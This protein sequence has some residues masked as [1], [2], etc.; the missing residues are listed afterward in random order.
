MVE[1]FKTNVTS[2]HQARV[3]VSLIQYH[4]EGF[5]ANFDLQDCDHILR[6]EVASHRKIEVDPVVNL[7]RD[8]GVRAEVLPDDTDDLTAL[9]GRLNDKI[10]L[11]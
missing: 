2:N 6:I 5:R 3:V 4:F 11:A 8:L 9:L 1:V 7:L 10:T